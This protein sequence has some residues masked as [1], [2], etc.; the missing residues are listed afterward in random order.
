MTPMLVLMIGAL[1]E[2]VHYSAIIGGRRAR[3]NIIVGGYGGV[4][5][6]GMSKVSISAINKR[7]RHILAWVV[8]S[9]KGTNLFLPSKH[10]FQFNLMKYLPVYGTPKKTYSTVYYF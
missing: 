1:T 10:F 6:P 8:R 5:F 3:F 9:D 2:D 4:V 7:G